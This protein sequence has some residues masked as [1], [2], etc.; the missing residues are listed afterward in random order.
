M[1]QPLLRAMELENYVLS[2]LRDQEG[3]TEILHAGFVADVEHDGVV[4]GVGETGVPVRVFLE[5]TSWPVIDRTY[6][7]ILLD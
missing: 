4:V 2:S 6:T 1:Q 7:V 3:V 5:V